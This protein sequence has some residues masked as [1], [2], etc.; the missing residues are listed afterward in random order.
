ME[1]QTAFYIIGI[2]FMSLMLILTIGIVA[3]LLVVRSKINAIHRQIEDKL[4]IITNIA[5]T[6]AEVVDRAKRMVTRR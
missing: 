2:I 4:S 1:L 3:A 5:N 6:G